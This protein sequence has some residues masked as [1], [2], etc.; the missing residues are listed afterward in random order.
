MSFQALARASSSPSLPRTA[1]QGV[2]FSFASDWRLVFPWY[3]GVLWQFT[4]F[5]FP[6][7][8]AVGWTRERIR[9]LPLARR[10]PFKSSYGGGGG[11]SGHDPSSACYDRYPSMFL[12]FIGLGSIDWIRSSSRRSPAV[13]DRGCAA[14]LS[15]RESTT[16]PLRFSHRGLLFPAPLG[17]HFLLFVSFCIS[18]GSFLPRRSLGSHETK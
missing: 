18:H 1:L 16:P 15:S 8:M 10:I 5:C 7:W 6:D 13:W 14:T 4:M 9:L 3:N 11:C 17:C 12:C 2:G